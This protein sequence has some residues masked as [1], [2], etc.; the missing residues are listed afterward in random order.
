[1]KTT[2]KRNKRQAQTRTEKNPPLPNRSFPRFTEKTTTATPT[3][4]PHSPHHHID[5]D[6]HNSR[7]HHHQHHHVDEKA[8]DGRR[9]HP[10]TSP[11]TPS[12]RLLFRTHAHKV[13]RQARCDPRARLSLRQR[14]IGG[15]MRLPAVSFLRALFL[16]SKTPREEVRGV[17]TTRAVPPHTSEPRPWSFA[18]RQPVM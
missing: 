7:H 2:T 16:P 12:T 10:K 5:I 9:E 6:H 14:F 13:I 8:S 18:W 15:L 17:S 1:M 11:Q 3:T 4:P